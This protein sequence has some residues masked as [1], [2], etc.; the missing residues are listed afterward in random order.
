MD[1]NSDFG[2]D[3]ATPVAP[4]TTLSK[5]RKAAL[6]VQLLISDGGKLSLNQLP[7]HIQEML[8]LELG[9]IRLVDRDTVN[10]VAEEFASLLESVG[11]SA[12]GGAPA[13]INAL[14][15]NLSPSLA[16]RLQARFGQ[17]QS[18]D[19]WAQLAALEEDTLAKVLQSES[20]LIA[21]VAL[22]KFP[23]EKAAGI[24]AALPGDRARQ[25]TLA[26]SQ[27]TD[28]APDAVSRI[29]A[30]LVKDYCQPKKTA[31]DK[32]PTDRVGAILNY[33]PAATRDAL[34]E[35]L[36]ED[37][38]D[39]AKGVRKVIFTFADIPDRVEETDIPNCIRAIDTET[40]ATAIATASAMEGQ[41]GK[42]ATFILDNISQRMAA[43]IKEEAEAKGNVKQSMGEDAMKQIV[44]AIRAQA[45]LGAIKFK[46]P[47]EENEEAA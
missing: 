4:D 43:Q 25:I 21:A 13:A 10:A 31:F 39:F 29:G 1:M 28:V 46:E 16:R 45:D 37:D 11:L 6:I 14:A 34:L 44:S 22:S 20:I 33:S 19:P 41:T 18:G 24:L 3:M 17:A 2:L 15:D 27:T 9:A 12:P 35:G 5:R 32:A 42:A 30:A 8:A 26:V 38:A 7:E 23:V 40:L 47:P 36:D